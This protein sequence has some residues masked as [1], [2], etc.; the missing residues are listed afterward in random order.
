M[1]KLAAEVAAV[2]NADEDFAATG[3]QSATGQL[4]RVARNNICHAAQGEAELAQLVLRDLDGDL[5][6]PNIGKFDL[7]D[8]AG[9]Q[10]AVAHL[11]G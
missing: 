3:L 11:F 2:H 6:F 4:Q 5:V 9:L 7:G 8:A 1:A 10:D